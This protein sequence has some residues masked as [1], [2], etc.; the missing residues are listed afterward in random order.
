M[1]LERPEYWLTYLSE[2]GDARPDEVTAIAPESLQ[3]SK[4]TRDAQVLLVAA[5]CTTTATRTSAS[6]SPPLSP[7]GY[8]S[9]TAA[10]GTT[11]TS[12][13][14]AHSKTSIATPQRC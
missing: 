8:T 9:N 14:T 7:A 10:T 11:S 5:D 4:L 3:R 1:S 2:R 12:T 13:S 6:S